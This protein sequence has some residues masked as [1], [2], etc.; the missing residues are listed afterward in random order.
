L[1]KEQA[2]VLP[3]LVALYD[4]CLGSLKG[5]VPFSPAQR[6]RV[7]DPAWGRLSRTMFTRYGAYILIFVLYLGLHFYALEGAVLKD[8]GWLENPAA[9]A[10]W[11]VRTMTSLK[12]AGTYLRLFVWPAHLSADYS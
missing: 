4:V 11:A 9:E 12:V 10:G 7:M 1:S 5:A 8:P 3:L 6:V 2:I